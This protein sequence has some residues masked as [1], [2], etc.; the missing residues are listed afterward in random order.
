MYLINRLPSSALHGYTTNPVAAVES[1][2]NKWITTTTPSLSLI[3]LPNKHV[4][5]LG[6]GNSS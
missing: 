4:T 5:T 1:T 6:A 2:M 3:P